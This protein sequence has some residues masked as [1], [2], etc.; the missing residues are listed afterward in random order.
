VVA[1]GVVLLTALL[2]IGFSKEERFVAQVSGETG[3]GRDEEE[4]EEEEEEE[5]GDDD[6]HDDM[7]IR[8]M[9]MI[10]GVCFAD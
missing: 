2:T 7:M 3:E 10:L 6:D 8:M 9:M 1:A 4:E 5:D